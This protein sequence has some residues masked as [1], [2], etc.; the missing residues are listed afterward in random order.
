MSW[1]SDPEIDWS[2]EETKNALYADDRNFYK[3]EKWTK[4]GATVDRLLYAGNNLDK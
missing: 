2:E 4:D 3:V 1:W